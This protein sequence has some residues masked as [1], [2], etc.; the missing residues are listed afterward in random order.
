MSDN[1]WPNPER[2]GEPLNP[3][4]DG[5]HWCPEPV[6]WF[7]RI[8]AWQTHVEGLGFAWIS[9]AT[10]E[11]KGWSYVGPC[12]TPAEISS[13]Q[14]EIVRLRADLAEMER[15]RDWWQAESLRDHALLDETDNARKR[16]EEAATA[17]GEILK[18]V[19]K[20]A[21][22]AGLSWGGKN[23]I[24]DRR[25]IDY[26]QAAVHHYEV[27]DV[28]AAAWRERTA[29]EVAAAR[30]A[31]LDEERESI[32]TTIEAMRR[33]YSDKTIGV[34]TTGEMGIAWSQAIDA[35]RARSNT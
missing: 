31:A 13:M 25:S 15:K 1:R 18:W 21:C 14:D 28:L 2:P 4:V 12:H 35:I 33:A 16:A 9:S 19:A 3:D 7:A 26:V 8:K 6:F 23:I 34:P 29:A 22:H 17:A 30:R 27:R 32:V 24:G 10:A 11:T 20:E 5:W